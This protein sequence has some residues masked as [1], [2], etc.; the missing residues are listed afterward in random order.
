MTYHGVPKPGWRAFQLLN[1]HAGTLRVGTTVSAAATI[2]HPKP[3]SIPVLGSE[4][5]DDP[6]C[7]EIPGTDFTGFGEGFR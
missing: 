7:Y 2:P 5:K 4:Q 1:S 3:Q 6:E